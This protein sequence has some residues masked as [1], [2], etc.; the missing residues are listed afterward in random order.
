[1]A[2]RG[3]KPTPRKI[4][5]LSGRVH[6][7]KVTPLDFGELTDAD[8]E[9]DIFT[10][11]PA[12][13][14]ER[15]GKT[16]SLLTGQGVLNPCDAEP[17]VRYVQHLRI[18]YMA[19]ELIEREGILSVDKNGIPHKHP[20]LQIHRDNSLAALRYEEQ[21]GLTPSARMRLRGSDE[22]K[23]DR[24]VAAFDDFVNNTEE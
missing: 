2:K 19:N 18:F 7:K 1:M 12:G 23:T 21:F 9:R 17:F 20:A 16:L 5:E 8:I 24:E 11:L 13:V 10:G 3:K 22:V 6:K 4:L 15:A 14:A